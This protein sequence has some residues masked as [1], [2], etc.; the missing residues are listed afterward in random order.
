MASKILANIF[1]TLLRYD[2]ENLE[3]RPAL[4]ESLSMSPDGT[5]W[6]F[7]LRRNIVFHDGTPF[8]AEAVKVSFDRQ[9]NP[10]SGFYIGDKN[11]YGNS[12]LS[13]IDHTDI[14][15]EFTVR[16]Y[17]KYPYAPFH[18][19]LATCFGSSIVSPTALRKY[20]SEFGRHPVG[21]G[22]FRFD[23]WKDGK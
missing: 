22:P 8:N 1:D 20:G 5:V 11:V 4:A 23:S 12:T 21:T 17:L 10:Q 3:T 6:T 18:H 15:D 7:Y 13:M 9:I 14:V 16:F 2:G 19:N